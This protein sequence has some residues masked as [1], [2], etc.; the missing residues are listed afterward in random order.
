MDTITLSEDFDDEI[1]WIILEKEREQAKEQAKE[2]EKQ[3]NE[4]GLLITKIN[5]LF[6]E[7]VKIKDN[8]KKRENI[9]DYRN[10]LIA[11]ANI[12]KEKYKF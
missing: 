3:Y 12:I 2:R 7:F 1:M 9:I 10:E 6:E 11:Q 8:P 4:Y 5:T